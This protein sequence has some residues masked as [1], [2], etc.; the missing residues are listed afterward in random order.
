FQ[1]FKKENSTAERLNNLILSAR[2][3]QV[4]YVQSPVSEIDPV[5]FY[6]DEIFYL[7]GI[8]VSRRGFVQDR[9][10][11]N[12][13]IVEDIPIGLSYGLTAGIHAKKSTVL[14]FKSK[15]SEAIIISHFKSACQIKSVFVIF[16]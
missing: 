2:F 9:Y 8:G 6:A 11:H 16:V 4:N 3:F 14:G 1:L 10:I 15:K 13:D 7:L 5:N 12:Y